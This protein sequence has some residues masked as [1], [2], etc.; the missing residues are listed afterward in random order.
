MMRESSNAPENLN[1]LQAA[2]AAADAK[3]DVELKDVHDKKPDN[4]DNNAPKGD[5]EGEEEFV[6][7]PI[8]ELNIQPRGTYF[9][10]IL[11]IS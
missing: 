3:S 5:E 8:F 4:G 11:T 9:S 7:E 6:E 1:Q 10:T 2:I